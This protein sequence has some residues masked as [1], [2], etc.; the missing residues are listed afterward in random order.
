MVA[1]AGK[2]IFPVLRGLEQKNHEFKTN[3]G[4]KKKSE[5]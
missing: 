3:L 5:E 2:S 1:Q 4:L